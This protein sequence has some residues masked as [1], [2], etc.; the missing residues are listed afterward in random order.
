[1]KCL[2]FRKESI[3]NGIFLNQV[4]KFLLDSLVLSYYKVSLDGNGG[5][6]HQC[7]GSIINENWIVTAAHCHS[8]YIHDIIQC[9]QF[10]F[11][12]LR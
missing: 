7:G 10:G 4:I 6:D 5:S 8:W 11:T 3:L 1:M 9:L 12:N 2:S